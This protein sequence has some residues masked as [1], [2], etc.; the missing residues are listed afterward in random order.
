MAIS[1]SHFTFGDLFQD[2]RPRSLVVYHRRDI[3]SFIASDM[4]HVKYYDVF[5][6]TIYTRMV[7]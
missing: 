2:R 7:L 6:A 1:A 5:F 3:C 4:I